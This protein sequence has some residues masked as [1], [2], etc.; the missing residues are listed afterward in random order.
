MYTNLTNN[1]LRLFK[2]TFYEIGQFSAFSVTPFS[3]NILSD[4]QETQNT[5]IIHVSQIVHS[6]TIIY[7][8]A[9]QNSTSLITYKTIFTKSI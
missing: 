6:T 7:L 8:T 2:E 3:E 5:Q 9:H 4:I 1:K